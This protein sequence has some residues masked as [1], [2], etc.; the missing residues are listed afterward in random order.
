[1]PGYIKKNKKTL[2]LIP[3]LQIDLFAGHFFGSLIQNMNFDSILRKHWL[4]SLAVAVAAMILVISMTSRFGIG[5]SPDSACYISIAENVIAGNGYAIYDLEPAVAWPPLYPT[6][7]ALAGLFDIDYSLWARILNVLLAGGIVLVISLWLLNNFGLSLLS[8]IG[9]LGTLLSSTLLSVAKFAWT[10]PMFNLLVVFFLFIAIRSAKTPERKDI[11]LLSILAAL[12]TMTRYIGV[13]LIGFYLLWL[14]ISGLPPK[15]KLKYSLI[16]GG[17]SI[18]PLIIW[19]IRNY[20]ITSTLTGYRASSSVPVF[21]NILYMLDTFSFWLFTTN[22]YVELRI[23]VFC[24]LLALFFIFLVRVGSSSMLLENAKEKLQL[25]GL[26]ALIYVLYL[27]IVSSIVAF[28]RIDYRL[29]SPVYVPILLFVIVAI[30][31]LNISKRWLKQAAAIFSVVWIVF[32]SV[33]L[34]KEVKA[35]ISEGAGGYSTISWQN[36]ELAGYLRENP[37]DGITYSNIPDGIYALTGLPATMS[38]RKY[39]RHS[40]ESKID[41][42]DLLN[43][44]LDE[45]ESVY[46]AWFTK[47]S[48]RF[49]Y[50]PD[51]LSSNFELILIVEKIDGAFYRIR[52]KTAGSD[53]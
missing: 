10:E 28:D 9:V 41:D 34:F 18:A 8:L 4:I 3:A 25:F 30:D 16:F 48:R 2:N 15:T 7:L 38:P 11:L 12:A 40:P 42:L 32:L 17:L 37:P 13:T 26:F 47:K 50:E 43:T 29:L 14:W 19:L 24:L 1:V 53:R 49:L 33:G 44:K 6:V 52:N 35:A 36:S 46:L 20:S 45:Y 21:K 27:I 51:E 39:P 5:I 22:S 31:S 23:A